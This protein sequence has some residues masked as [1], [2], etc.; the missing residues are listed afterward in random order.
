M[1]R[2]VV[3]VSVFKSRYPRVESVFE[4]VREQGQNRDRPRSCAPFQTARSL[5]WGKE[6]G[7]QAGDLESPPRELPGALTYHILWLYR[8]ALCPRSKKKPHRP[9]VP[10]L[11]GP[12]RTGRLDLTQRVSAWSAQSVRKSWANRLRAARS[13]LQFCRRWIAQ[14]DLG[15]LQRGARRGEDPR[16]GLSPLT[17]HARLAYSLGK[18]DLVG[19][20]ARVR[21]LG[22][23]ANRRAKS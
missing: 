12:V 7:N 4:S 17:V 11:P 22:R 2:S 14:Q 3:L 5:G 9:A 18:Q 6:T 16:S 21:G 10:P 20:K 8:R 1:V 13:P 15:R 23:F 19:A